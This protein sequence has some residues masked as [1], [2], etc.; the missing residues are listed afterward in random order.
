LRFTVEANLVSGM[1]AFVISDLSLL[2]VP[3]DWMTP[4]AI[5]F[6][7]SGSKTVVVV[8]LLDKGTQLHPEGLGP[9]EVAESVK[10]LLESPGSDAYSKPGQTLIFL[11]D[12]GEPITVTEAREPDPVFGKEWAAIIGGIAGGFVLFGICFYFGRRQ[13][14]AYKKE[15]QWRE[16]VAGVTNDKAKQAFASVQARSQ[17]NLNSGVPSSPGN[18]PTSP[19]FRTNTISSGWEKQWDANQGAFYYTNPGTGESTWDPPPGVNFA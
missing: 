8:T 7:K 14:Y 6:Q 9:L 5:T 18:S 19:D 1:E 15:H 12:A 4:G 11:T 2:G 3:E 17:Q 10:A 13:Y 16:D